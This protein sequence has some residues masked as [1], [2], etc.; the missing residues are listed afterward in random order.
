[1]T[2]QLPLPLQKKRYQPPPFVCVDPDGKGKPWNGVGRRPDYVKKAL[3]ETGMYPVRPS[4]EPSVGNADEIEKL[5]QRISDL[6]DL[7]TRHVRESTRAMAALQRRI[8]V[9]EQRE[10]MRR[11]A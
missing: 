10:P 6:V 11:A 1:M 7:F 3:R 2:T 9:L 8:D 4:I 5:N